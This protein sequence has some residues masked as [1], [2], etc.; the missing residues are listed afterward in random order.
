MELNLTFQLIVD[1]SSNYNKAINIRGDYPV[2]IYLDDDIAD[3]GIDQCIFVSRKLLMCVC[4]Y[5]ATIKLIAYE[6]NGILFNCIK[7]FFDAMKENLSKLRIFVWSKFL[8]GLAR[9][10]I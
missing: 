2:Q 10:R 6:V 3:N 4:H 8:R 1:I 7:F 9:D 5:P